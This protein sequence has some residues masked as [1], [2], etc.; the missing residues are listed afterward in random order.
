MKKF[1]SY[2][3]GFLSCALLVGAIGTAGAAYKKA[4]TLDFVGMKLKLDGKYVDVTDSRGNKIEPFAID[5]TTYLPV[6]NLAR[7]IGY[8]VKWDGSTQTVSL[9]KGSGTPTV[10]VPDTMTRGQENALKKAK[11]YLDFSAFSRDG[12]V[13]QLEYEKF[14]HADAV[15]GVDHCGADWFEQAVRKGKSYLDFSSFSREGLIEQLEYE[16][17]T[18]EQAVY[19]VDKLGF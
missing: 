2:M 17:F 3:M 14:S 10:S 1:K 8:E 5:G 18:H 6:A 4:A 12:L 13:S 19:A 7:M 16:K 15:F 9:T 11:S